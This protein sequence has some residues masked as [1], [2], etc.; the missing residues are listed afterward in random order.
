MTEETT[1][2]CPA[3][4]P[5]GYQCLKKDTGRKHEHEDKDARTWRDPEE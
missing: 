1:P 5:G 2:Q 3:V 4:H